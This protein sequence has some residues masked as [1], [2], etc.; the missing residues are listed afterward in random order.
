MIRH[1]KTHEGDIYP[2]LGNLGAR[3]RSNLE[4]VFASE[5][6]R[7]KSSGEVGP[8]T[9]GS[10]IFSLHFPLAPDLP[11]DRPDMVNDPVLYDVDLRER[12]MKVALLLEGVYVMHAGGAISLAHTEDDMGKMEEACRAVAVRL[13][14]AGLA[15]DV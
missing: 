14:W 15:G 12:V 1:L 10:S 3:L 8:A 9:V 4:S 7:V 2:R 6:I 5:G 11:A 13:R